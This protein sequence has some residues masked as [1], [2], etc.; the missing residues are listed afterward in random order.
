MTDPAALAARVQAGDRNALAQAIT[1]VESTRDD[2]RDAAD[3]LLT[4]ILPAS[5]NS[6][7]LGVTGAP[8]V[9]KST[10]I[11]VFGLMSL[12]AG[13]RVAV[14]A[15]DPSSK[16]TG[17][18]ILGDKTRMGDLAREKDA[19]IR[20]S[21]AGP[22]LGGVARR[23]REAVWLCEAAG[24]DLVIVETVGVGQSETAVADL[25]D[26][27]LLMIAPGA[28]DE[29]QGIKKGI[30]EIADMLAVNKADGDLAAAAQRAA[31]EYSHAL[32][33]LRSAA[34]AVPVFAVSALEKRGIEKLRQHVEAAA[35]GRVQ[36]GSLSRKRA[37]QARAALWGEVGESLLEALKRD[38]AVAG[39]LPGLE[40]EVAAGRLTPSGAAHRALAA[41]RGARS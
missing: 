30:V 5:G 10:F 36:D 14:L 1:L 33:L 28:G 16:T 18:S 38:P 39:L 25:V 17:G 12:A 20:P 26:L 6:L 9:G 27:C 15:V 40:A 31:S 11:E 7:R 13:R 19:F 35:Y 37:A 24:F 23:T 2:H 41:F 32:R 21:P 29:L 8:G 4:A 22:M 34:A 3:A